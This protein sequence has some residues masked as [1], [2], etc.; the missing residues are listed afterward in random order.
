[1]KTVKKHFQRIIAQIN[2]DVEGQTLLPFVKKTDEDVDHHHPSSSSSS[3]S[4]PQKKRQVYDLSSQVIR[5][6]APPKKAKFII[7]LK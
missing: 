5:R 2:A 4:I 6:T 3:S 1:M 7:D